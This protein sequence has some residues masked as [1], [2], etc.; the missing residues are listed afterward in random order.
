M[1]PR[2]P[3]SFDIDFDPTIQRMSGIAMHGDTMFDVPFI[4]EVDD[5]LWQGGCHRS[6]VLPDFITDIVSLYRWEQYEVEHDLKSSLTVEMY[7]DESGPDKEQIELIATWI[8]H[9]KY[10]SEHSKVLV[11]CQ[12]GLN[13]SG[14][15]SAVSLV[16]DDRNKI[17]TG[18]AAINLL[19]ESRSDAVLCNQTFRDWITKN[20]G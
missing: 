1:D 6:L 5:H 20:Y 15:L 8:N 14:L 19:R 17:D 9:R 18:T 11:H 16:L 7:D 13:R 2:D 4:S 3:T 10:F 12:A